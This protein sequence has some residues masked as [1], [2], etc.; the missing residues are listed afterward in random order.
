MV[1]VKERVK[2]VNS[3]DSAR[4]TPEFWMWASHTNGT[5]SGMSRVEYSTLRSGMIT[6]SFYVSYEIDISRMGS[7][8]LHVK[9]AKD[10]GV[11][12]IYTILGGCH[13]HESTR[14]RSTMWRYD[15]H[16]GYADLVRK[17]KR[18]RRGWQ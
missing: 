5:Y 14:E 13:C 7:F 2:E 1:E 18:L 15:F 8:S 9:A 12:H 3:F 11:P 6:G 4:W 16:A 10:K 17:Q